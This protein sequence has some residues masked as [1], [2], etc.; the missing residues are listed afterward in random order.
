[1]CKTNITM[2]MSL[3]VVALMLVNILPCYGENGTFTVAEKQ[4]IANLHFEKLPQALR[5]NLMGKKS[6][7]RR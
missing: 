5:F 2:L 6:G 1:M 3:S 7:D 4:F